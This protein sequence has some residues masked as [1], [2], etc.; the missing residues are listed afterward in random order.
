[1]PSYVN[2]LEE[3]TL[4]EPVMIIAMAGWNDASS[5][6]TTSVR[7]LVDHWQAKKFAEIDPE[8]F[9]NFMR[10]RPQVRLDPEGNRQIIWPETAFHYHSN[11][12]LERDFVL[13][14][15]IEPNIHWRTFCEQVVD[16]ARAVNITSVLSLGGLAAQ[17]PHTLS[18]R[19]TGST[20][21]ASLARQFPQLEVRRSRY[22]GP[23]GIVG[24]L[25]D[26]FNKNGIPTGSLWGNVPHYISASPNPKVAHGLLSRLNTMYQLGLNLDDLARSGRRFE[27]QVNEALSQNPEVAQYV[28]QLEAAQADED[29]AP[30]EQLDVSDAD[31]EAA[32]GELPRAEDV[33][34]HLEEFLRQGR[35]GQAEGDS[36]D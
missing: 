9:F 29:D 32:G 4:R 1:M 20:N 33:V 13:L 34:R 6:A 22:E 36:E 11:P 17:V 26:M 10:I 28:K 18:A 25:S 16:V 14:I 15:G 24:V 8:E 30:D 21:D 23:T 3:P 31:D 2:W 35:Q 19:V 12:L 27:R 7:Y 5:V